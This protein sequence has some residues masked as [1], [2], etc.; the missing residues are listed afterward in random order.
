[1]GV[2]N[3]RT[4][5]YLL[6]IIDPSRLVLHG[7]LMTVNVT[8]SDCDGRRLCDACRTAA[9]VLEAAGCRLEHSTRYAAL[10]A[11]AMGS[12]GFEACVIPAAQD[13]HAV[14]DAAIALLAGK[15]VLLVV[16]QADA[17]MKLPANV[18]PLARSRYVAGDFDA[19][20]ASD[21]QP[22]SLTP[23]PDEPSATLP[24][25]ETM[26]PSGDRDR[27]TRRL[28]RIADGVRFDLA[29]AGL[30][31]APRLDMIAVLED[32]IA[33]AQA[34][35]GEFCVVLVHLPGLCAT[36]AA[37]G[38]IADHRV[39]A[40]QS[41]VASAIR[42]GDVIAGRG[43]DFLVVL[44]DAD[45]AGARTVVA[46][47]TTALAASKLRGGAKT[48]RAR[49]FAAWSIGHARF[50]SD[51]STRDALLARATASLKPI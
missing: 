19:R 51:G 23:A 20:W 2:A 38:V 44:P 11:A 4:R 33:W 10:R 24:S 47:L 8:C 50:P 13:E 27:A 12:Y 49:G 37:A 1:M 42:S 29:R 41:L 5:A 40:A 26:R 22:S 30:A 32:E 16:D 46:R 45:E 6:R 18:T 43:D 28:K 7:N 14:V 3:R 48:R 15:R 34:S 25:P 17:H 35:S 36:K 39:Q 31:S 21:V 9:R